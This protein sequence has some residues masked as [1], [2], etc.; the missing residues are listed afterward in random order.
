MKVW[1][2]ADYE[3]RP[4][5]HSQQNGRT[6]CSEQVVPKLVTIFFQFDGTFVL[7]ISAR[8]FFVAMIESCQSKAQTVMQS[9]VFRRGCI[10]GI[11]ESIPSRAPF[12]P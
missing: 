2:S 7:R 8:S 10:S 5:P 4:K 12:T 11:S 9:D 1:V 6:K 3:G